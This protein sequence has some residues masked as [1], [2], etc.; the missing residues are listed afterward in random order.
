MAGPLDRLI[1]PR[2]RV[3]DVRAAALEKSNDE[4]PKPMACVYDLLVDRLTLLDACDELYGVIEQ[5]RIE[6]QDAHEIASEKHQR[7]VAKLRGQ[8]ANVTHLARLFLMWFEADGEPV[9]GFRF[10]EQW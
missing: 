7:T 9:D 2:L 1:K 6:R 5:L 3:Q 8:L 4:L 10:R